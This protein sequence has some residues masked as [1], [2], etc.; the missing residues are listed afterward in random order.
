V[1][2]VNFLVTFHRKDA[3]F[4]HHMKRTYRDD[5]IK[6]ARTPGFLLY[7]MGDHLIDG[8]RRAIGQIADKVEQVQLKLF[9]QVDD[10]IFRYVSDLTSDILAFRRLNM[11]SREL[12]HQLGTRK[13]PFVS[14]STQPFLESM[15]G[16]VMRL[17]GDLTTE[18]EVL[19]ETLNLYMGMVTHR[20]NKVINRLT[21]I[22]IIFLPLSFLCGVYGMNLKG[23]P[24]MEWEYGYTAFWTVVILLAGGL[25]LTMRRLRWI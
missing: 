1:A 3:E 7:E 14:D 20:T 8:Y 4:L 9:G 22:S 15:A 2:G 13:S 6:F 25:L 10:E 11:A 18:R 19:N 23:M 5:F 17:G 16:T 24:E 21:V 12:L